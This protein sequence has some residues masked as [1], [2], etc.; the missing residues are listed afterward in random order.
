MNILRNKNLNLLFI[1]NVVSSIGVGITGIAVPWLILSIYDA[2]KVYGLSYLLLTITAFFLSPYIGVL[3]DQYSRKKIIIYTETV[4][5][6]C[7]SLICFYTWIYDYIPLWQLVLLHVIGFFYHSFQIPCIIAIAQEITSSEDYKKV[8]SLLEIQSQTSSLAGAG[9]AM[10]ALTYLK[11]QHILL[12]D[13]LTFFICIVMMMLLHYQPKKRNSIKNNSPL[14]NFVDGMQY[15]K[16]K[17]TLIVFLIFSLF[18][19]ICVMLSNYLTPVHL[20]KTLN[21][22]G[23]Y[24][25]AVDFVYAIGAV[26]A[27]LLMPKLLNK[28]NPYVLS[29]F[30]TIIFSIAILCISFS[31]N[32]THYVILYFVIAAGN[33]CAKVSV[34]TVLMESVENEYIGRVNSVISGVNLG[35]RSI[36]IA[37]ATMMISV[38]GTFLIY[39][40][41]FI[42]LCISGIVIYISIRKLSKSKHFNN[43]SN[44]A[45]L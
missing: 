2:E 24:F 39:R 30:A 12:F 44:S 36:F 9:L 18:P 8:S 43:L 19:F 28:W 25:G 20:A 45:D 35:I 27:G 31:S 34:N 38:V 15:V 4:G 3:V 42:M 10:L 40:M 32:A 6:I 29:L 22:G 23:A 16:S 37:F 41:V 21:V 26:L 5:F 14:K 1:G 13:A 11:I 17:A 33:I 7:I